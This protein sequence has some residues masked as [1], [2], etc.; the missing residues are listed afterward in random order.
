[1][2]SV[3]LLIALTFLANFAFSQYVYT[4]KA[5]SVKITN[6]DSAELILENHTQGVPG[7]LYNTGNGRTQFRRGLVGLGN[8]SYVIGADTLQLGT[9]A[10]LQGGNAFGTTGVLGTLDNNHLDLY[11]N[12]TQRVRVTSTGNLLVGTTF[13]GGSKLWVNG[14]TVLNGTFTQ[15]YG[16]PTYFGNGLQLDQ[17]GYTGNSYLSTRILSGT[18]ILYMSHGVNDQHLFA[19][20]IG[21]QMTGNLVTM[22]PG[23]YSWSHPDSQFVLKVY[24]QSSANGLFVNLYGNTGIGTMYPTAKLHVSGTVRFDALTGDSSQTRVLVTDANG[25]LFYRDASSLA[26]NDLPRSSL[27]VNGTITAK[28]LTLRPKDWPDYVFDSSYR[29][30]SLPVIESYIRQQHHLPD[31]PS[32]KEVEKNGADIGA[33]QAAMLKKIEEL[34]LYSIAQQKELEEQNKKLEMQAQS[35]DALQQQI[36][37]LRQLLQN[38]SRK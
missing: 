26:A 6:C 25:N 34:T 5:D 11:T 8:G 21:T 20:E 37:E 24:G 31:I 10:W 36:V 1:M 19:N 22:D 33:N 16:S 32:A 30:P 2:R 35:M 15:G 28:Q 14:N 4:I 12:D 38:K 13:D 27:A 29:L 18:E 9:H 23:P 3:L 17:Y 7:F